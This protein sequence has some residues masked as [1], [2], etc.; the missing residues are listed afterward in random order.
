MNNR[1]TSKKMESH[2]Y[3]KIISIFNFH[4]WGTTTLSVM[5]NIILYFSLVLKSV[6]PKK[7]KKNSMMDNWDKFCHVN[8]KMKV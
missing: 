3:K 4:L 7:K 5:L 8:Y 6:L 2:W 1:R